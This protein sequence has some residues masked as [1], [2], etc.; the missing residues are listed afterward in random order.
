MAADPAEAEPP[1]VTAADLVKAAKRKGAV[2]PTKPGTDS[3][4]AVPQHEQERRAQP[5]LDHP[6]IAGARDTGST[7]GA[8]PNP[9]SRTSFAEFPSTVWMRIEQVRDSS[10]ERAR[11]A[12]AGLCEDYW[13]PIYAFI[14]RKGNDPDRAADLTQDFFT[15]LL[16][17]GAFA[18]VDAGK[19]KFRSFLMVACTHFLSNRRVYERAL[20][21]GGGRSP[22]SIDQRE[23]EKRLRYEPFHEMTPERIFLRQWA[24][25]LIDLVMARLRSEASLNGRSRLFDRIRPALLGRERA[26]SYAQIAAEL[27]VGESTVKVAVHRFRARYRALLREEIA[28]TT[29]DP[30]EIDEEISSLLQALAD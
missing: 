25:A 22:V 10:A 23:A 28:R 20:K 7:A 13:R 24:T 18:A 2:K 27:G 11:D 29:A 26:P 6:K 14:R 9:Q 1:F 16:E 8:L 19:G 21:R 12:L 4:A 3:R 5:R 15:L 30:A 17:P